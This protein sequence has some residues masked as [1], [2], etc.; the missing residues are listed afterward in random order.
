MTLLLYPLV[1]FY[2]YMTISSHNITLVY[3]P[4]L[5][6]YHNTIESSWWTYIL[7][8]VLLS[9][10]L[11]RWCFKTKDELYS[12]YGFTGVLTALFSTN[13]DSWKTLDCVC[14]VSVI[15]LDSLA[16]VSR[17]PLCMT[18]IAVVYI[19]VVNRVT[20]AT[21]HLVLLLISMLWG[22]F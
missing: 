12:V 21:R 17:S 8:N 20:C 15:R 9:N 1:R 11:F 16:K 7:I 13:R 18:I 14:S 10:N 2:C 5:H 22:I 6:I 3:H 4:P 19:S